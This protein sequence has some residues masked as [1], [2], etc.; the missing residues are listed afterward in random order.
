[1][2]TMTE[3][4]C[5]TLINIPTD[6]EP[7]NELQLKQDLEKGS[8]QTKIDALKKTIH[9]ILS[10][11]RLPGLL[12]TIIRFVLPLQNHTI[13]KLL[14]IF[15]EIVPKTSGDGKLLQEMILVCDAY[16][17]DLQHPNEFVRGSTLR[18][19]CKLKEPELLEPL[20]PAITGCLE[21]RHSYVRRNAV[22]AIFT[23]YRNF[24]FLIPDAPDLIAKYLEGE[25]DMSC[26]RNAF[27]M[28]L[29]AD[30][31]K[32]LAYLAACLDQVPSF[33][34]ILQL[35]IVELI[36]KVCLANSSE[37][38]RFI[39]C[40]YSLLNSPSAAVR[41]EAAGTLVTLSNAPT[42]IKAA[43]SCYIELVVKESDN[44][45]KLIVL[46]RLIAM[47]DSPVHER[48][49]QDLVMDIL[50]VLGS[51]ALEVRTKTLA[52]AMD[53]VT[54]RTIEEMVQ[55]LKKEVLRTAGG[56]HEDAGKYRQLLIRTLHTC[57]MKF[58]DVAVTVIPVL[59]DFL[60]ESNEAAATDLLVFIREAI[61]RFENLRP[62]I[63]EKLL[64]V[65]PHIRS[66]KVHRAALWIL[67]EYAMSK[68]DIEAVMSRI[69]AAL[70]E[71]PL[72]EAENKRQ[73]GEKSEDGNSQATPAQLVTSDG[74]YATQS[75]FSAASARKKEEKRPALV[76]YMM[77]GE[78]F[79]GA[80]LATTLAKLSLRY[81]ILETNVQ[82]SNR[83]QAE[84]MFVMTSILQLGRSGLPTKAMTHDDA[85]RISLCL[86]SLACP[87]PLVQKV[88]TEGCR[89]AL[90][91]M[92]TAK[93]EEDSQNQKAK[94][95]PGN[96]VQ[97]DDAI[98]FLQL[99]RGSDLA[100]GAGDMFE[101]SLSAAVAGRPGA[102]GDAPSALSK[103]IQLTGFSDPVY[104]EALVH[105]NQYDIVLDVLIV[106]QTEDTLQNCT[107]E[108]ATLGDLKLVERPQPIVLAPRDFATIKANVKVTSTENG[109]IFG[110]IVY[111][112]SGA[113]SDRSVVV[114]NDIHIDIMDYIVPATC[115]DTE[116]RQ[117]WAEFEWENKVSVNTTLSDLREYLAHLLKSTNM[118]CL[119]PE[120]ALSGQCG[121]MAA[122]MYAKSIFGEDALANL[123]IEKPLNKPDA[124]V[125]GHIRIRAKSQGMAL[126]L[127]DKINSAQKDPLTKVVQ[128]A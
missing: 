13:K 121:F 94:E 104:A 100:G 10:G 42:A 76:Q 16:R 50:R 112:V 113:G 4:P 55:L 65:F 56:E 28:L 117:M 17:K 18:F 103:V 26:R 45:V 24:E 97:V 120:K 32:A 33:G 116:F 64:E 91:R 73:A 21:H 39:R 99:S 123:S 95:K 58:A 126:S 40:I 93:A 44:N 96:I 75:A 47:K 83:L 43:A 70:G 63:I 61:Q 115:T 84:A 46:D 74:T 118:R 19:L 54:T 9:M 38:A 122:N 92:L 125:V 114:L 1:M 20:M 81:K 110:N 49:L 66:V 7:L 78:F 30:Q 98:Q 60:S 77:E 67:G 8:V 12:M 86:R 29:H 71:L 102:S 107:L 35:V 80:S 51:P 14:L 11:E 128:V 69:R 106:N 90:G 23:I 59:T 105:V 22:L 48:V 3:Q 36:Y 41:Y 82:K 62:L 88:F 127:G 2:S 57:S 124:P 79:I 34:D 119:T 111:D 109:I 25:Q 27:L 52:L 15:W 87:T 6:T 5:Y 31:N 53:L 108:L 101:Q 37:R 85:E 89:D 68:E 72:L